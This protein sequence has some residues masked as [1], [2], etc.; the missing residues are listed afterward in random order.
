MALLRG[1]RSAQRV[2]ELMAEGESIMSSVNLGEVLY[3]LIRTHGTDIAGARVAGVRQVVDVVDPDWALVEAAANIKANARLSYA[4]AFCVATGERHEAPVA[5][6][7]P[8]ILAL[9]DAA[10]VIDLRERP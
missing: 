6:G 8:E 4:D 1:E 10:S 2:R 5:T 9:R 3:S 7:D